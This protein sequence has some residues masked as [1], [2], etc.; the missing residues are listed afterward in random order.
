MPDAYNHQLKDIID[1]YKTSDTDPNCIK[2]LLKQ[3]KQAA[4]E[5]NFSLPH[6]E[7][8]VD[9][10]NYINELIMQALAIPKEPI[11]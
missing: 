7:A 10:I 5:I 6:T 4:R 3:R 8:Y 11:K 9:Y 1:I 2:L